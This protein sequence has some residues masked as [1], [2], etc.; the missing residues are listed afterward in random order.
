MMSDMLRR[1]NSGTESISFVLFF[2]FFFFFVCAI[3]HCQIELTAL[4]D[5][6]DGN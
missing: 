3:K 6:P 1:K 2:L 5:E 4:S